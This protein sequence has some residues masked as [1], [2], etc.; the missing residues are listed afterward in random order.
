MLHASVVHSYI[1]VG[2]N[3]KFDGQRSQSS[4]GCVCMAVCVTIQQRLKGMKYMC[5]YVCV[6]AVRVPNRFKVMKYICIAVSA[7]PSGSVNR[8]SL[9]E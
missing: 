3:Q 2:G 8:A 9:T 5:I 1:G 4:C 7:R 6:M